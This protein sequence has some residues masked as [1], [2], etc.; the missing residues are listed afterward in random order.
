MTDS[1]LQSAL[2]GA[3]YIDIHCHRTT[4]PDKLE[5]VSIDILDFDPDKLAGKAY[6]LGIHPW[7]IE[8]QD[9]NQ[10]MQHLESLAEH[11]AVLAIGECG[12]D[13]AIAT[14]LAIQID[15][16][17]RQIALAE[18]IGKPLIIHCV[19]A[20]SELL[21]LKKQLC[22]TRPWIIHGFGGKPAL[23]KQ[24]LNH[25]CYLSFGALL[26]DARSHAAA[27]LRE[28][29]PDRVF[30]ETDSA[31]APIGEIVAAA[32]KIRGVDVATI[33]QQIQ[34]NFKRVFLND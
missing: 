1:V 24:L 30:L 23:A 12:L 10:T 2:S 14:P 34:S 31:D 33:R 15:V 5:I 13:K 22:P 9:T 21:H 3:V 7:F 25:G 26:L 27:A 32:A 8:H 19:R 4:A 28:A 20:F 29:P 16:F 11:P 18:R 6:T 17:H